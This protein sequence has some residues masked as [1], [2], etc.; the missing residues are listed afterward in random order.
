LILL[1]SS[2][3][4]TAAVAWSRP[5]RL[6]VAVACVALIAAFAQVIPASA[7]PDLPPWAQVTLRPTARLGP[8]K[9]QAWTPVA[10]MA[11]GGAPA[12][13]LYENQLGETDIR[14][15]RR[16]Q[17]GS[18]TDHGG[19]ASVP[20]ET[21]AERLLAGSVAMLLP[22]W[23]SARFHWIVMGG[24][25]G[26]WAFADLDKILFDATLCA[27]LVLAWRQ[28]RNGGVPHAVFWHVTIT[29]LF[30]AGPLV[31]TAANFGTL[32]RQRAMLCACVILLPLTISWP[33]ERD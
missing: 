18:S 9:S 17:T 32:L 14:I 20:P 2:T 19:P 25:R 28:F 4:V 10:S 29:T 31:Y 8:S 1:G 6:S 13:A 27:A 24:G 11:L 23:L 15:R 22:R 3:I 30:L 16:N 5:R 12:A 7:G 26:L 33:A 21:T